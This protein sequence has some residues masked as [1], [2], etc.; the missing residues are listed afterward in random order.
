VKSTN[1]DSS[2]GFQMRK[3]ASIWVNICENSGYWTSDG[4]L[5]HWTSDGQTD[6]GARGRRR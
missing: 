6:A 2:W 4:L 1:C 3:I 5:T